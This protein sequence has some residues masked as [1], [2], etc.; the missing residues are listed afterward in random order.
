MDF[1]C[2]TWPLVSPLSQSLLRLRLKKWVL[3]V[4]TVFPS[5]SRFIH[6]IIST[7]PVFQ[8]WTMAGIS[9]LASN[10]KPSS[11][12]SIRPFVCAGRGVVKC[13]RSAD[14]GLRRRAGAV[15]SIRCSDHPQPAEQEECADGREVE[16]QYAGPQGRRPRKAAVVGR[17]SDCEC[18]DEVRHHQQATVE[19]Y[20]EEGDDPRAE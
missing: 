9:P 8:S 14:G 12:G 13:A 7:W 16:P 6:A 10:F 18:R 19:G 3:P 11:C 5:E 17:R 4:A 20:E 1:T 15:I 2:W